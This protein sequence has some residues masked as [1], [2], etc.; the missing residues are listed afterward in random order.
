MARTKKRVA[1]K[2]K[3]T[4]PVAVVLG[5]LPLATTAI[6]DFQAGGINGLRNTATAIIP[7]SPANKRFTTAR[8][9]LGLYPILAGFM[10]HKLAGML[11]INRAIASA[12]VPLIR[13]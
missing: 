9:H 4:I 13:L 11:G 2:K 3:R 10:V 5:F 8:L 1:H 7:Y 12:G 6:S